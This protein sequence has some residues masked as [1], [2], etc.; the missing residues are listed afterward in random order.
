MAILRFLTSRFG[1]HI[2][3]WTF[4]KK[5]FISLYTKLHFF[6][7]ERDAE[8]CPKFKNTIRTHPSWSRKGEEHLFWVLHKI[9]TLFRLGGGIYL[10]TLNWRFKFHV[11]IFYSF[12]ETAEGS[13]WRPPPPPQSR[14]GQKCPV[15]IGLCA[16]SLIAFSILNILLSCRPGWWLN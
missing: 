7:L 1:L 6:S 13:V 14:D 11:Y 2:K 9:K 10:T 15:W 8:K 5:I 4:F 16:I 3:V 12:R